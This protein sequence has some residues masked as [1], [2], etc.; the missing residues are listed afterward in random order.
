MS[1]TAHLGPFTVVELGRYTV[2]PGEQANF[3][4]YFES[5][6]PEAFQQLGAL[7]CGHF[8]ERRA[9][10]SFTWLRAFRS[11]DA[12]AIFKASFYYGPVWKEHRQSLND[13]LVDWQNVLLLRPLSAEHGVPILPAVDPVRES[14]GARGVVLV[15]IFPLQAGRIEQFAGAATTLLAHA[16]DGA[17][18]AGVLVTLDEANNFPQHPV[19]A[20][21]PFF[22]QLTLL[23]NEA[24]RERYLAS[25]PPLPAAAQA[26]LCGEIEALTLD[27]AP[28]S[29]L[30]W[31]EEW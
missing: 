27:P 15:E 21:G 20:D 31:R 29:R 22:L 12:R 23:E 16:A 1:A 13:R 3:T 11:M 4:R 18:P 24:A 7:V 14:E 9:P 19:R 17:R 6:C 28:R 5:F 8:A 2:T 10:A 25:R 26:C 30:R